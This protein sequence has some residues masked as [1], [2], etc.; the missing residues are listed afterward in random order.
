MLK[1]DSYDIVLQEIPDEVSLCLT[2]TGCQLACEGCHSEHL[3]NP[4]NGTELTHDIFRNL[5]TKYKKTITCVLFMGGEWADSELIAL[6]S[7]TKR[8]KLKVGLYTGL[9][10]KQMKRKHPILLENLDYLKTGKWIAD[11]GGLNSISTNQ[12]LKDLTTG[13]ILNGY[14]LNNK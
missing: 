10:E 4:E 1:Y 5:I 8:E 7:M 3:W 11:L 12:V 2:I 9:N 13:R 6:I 14:F